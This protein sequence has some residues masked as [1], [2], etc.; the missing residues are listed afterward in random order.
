M[1][2]PDQSQAAN[3]LDWAYTLWSILV[4]GILGWCAWMWWK[5]PRST[6]EEDGLESLRLD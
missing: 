5:K 4:L 3:V 6:I 1:P 2:H